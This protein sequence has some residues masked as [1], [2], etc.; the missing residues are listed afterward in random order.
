MNKLMI[1]AVAAFGLF[2]ANA[3]EEN[4][5]AGLG[6][7]WRLSIGGFARGSMKASG[8]NLSKRCEA[9][10]A[11]LD[12]QYRAF[13]AGDFNLWAGIGGSMTPFQEIG[14]S[15]HGQ[16]ES[17]GFTT[18]QSAN[19]IKARISG[20]EFRLMLVPEYEI[21]D[22]WTI[23]AR[24]G[25]AFDWMRLS[26]RSSYW[27]KMAIDL[28]PP[29]VLETNGSESDKDT[30]F[31]TQ[32]IL[33]LQTTYMFTDNLGLYANIDYRCGGNVKFESQG[34]QVGELNMDGWYAGAGV[35]V[36]F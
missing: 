8:Q 6:N 33:G 5:N 12:L 21:A 35:V 10:G 11:D 22:S 20:G 24:I 2:A 23:G 25:C 13:K 15:H 28:T 7:N 19:D 27:S 36:A 30:E 34:Q 4:E 14:S 1:A 31:V 32:A 17:D 9:Y 3:A 26:Y 18:W 16:Y 29:L